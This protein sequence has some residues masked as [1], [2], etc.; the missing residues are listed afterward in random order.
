[1][2]RKPSVEAA[3]EELSVFI[4]ESVSPLDF[5]KERT[6]G[7]AAHGVLRAGGT[8]SAYRIVLN[9][10]MLRRA[11]K[12]AASGSYKALH[13][14]CHGDKVGLQLADGSDIDWEPL[15]ELLRP[16]AGKNRILVL[17][18]CTNGHVGLANALA[19]K[20]VIFGWLFGSSSKRVDF[21]HC[22]L[23]WSVLYNRLLNSGLDRA[24]LRKTLDEINAILSGE[25][26]YR[27]WDE[28][29]YRVY[30][31]RDRRSTKKRRNRGAAPTTKVG[32][33]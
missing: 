16:F 29:R 17:S 4:A 2:V 22:C 9:E 7:L 26:V 32:A 5:Y 31:R 33:N 28:T 23:A 21:T 11:V 19:K 3:A 24:G 15:A 27:R 18:S 25:F 1:M 6:D 12:E 8:R 14:S 13:V 30:P 10:K 20:R